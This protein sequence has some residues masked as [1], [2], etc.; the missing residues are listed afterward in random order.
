M[1]TWTMWIWGMCGFGLGLL[2]RQTKSSC[3]GR[4]LGTS[5]DSTSSS[6]HGDLY[7]MLMPMQ[8]PIQLVGKNSETLF[9]TMEC[10][11]F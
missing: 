6:A 9:R 11:F 2:M 8:S 1:E 3:G 10:K 4:G 7:L 5:K